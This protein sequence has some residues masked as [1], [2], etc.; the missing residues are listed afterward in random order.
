MCAA[1]GAVERIG[2]HQSGRGEVAEDRAKVARSAFGIAA[3]PTE[4]EGHLRDGG[5]VGEGAFA[6]GNDAIGDVDFGDI[7]IIGKSIFG[8]PGDAA[9]PESGGNP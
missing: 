3:I 1:G 2:F 6:D 5:I 9:T 8:D 4:R 7:G